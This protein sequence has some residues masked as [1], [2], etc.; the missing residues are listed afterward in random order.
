MCGHNTEPK[1]WDCAAGM[2]AQLERIKHRQ[3]SAVTCTNTETDLVH[4]QNS[5]LH[6]QLMSVHKKCQRSDW[7]PYRILL[8]FCPSFKGHTHTNCCPS[9]TD[10]F[11]VW[12]L[13]FSFVQ[14]LQKWTLDSRSYNKT[15]QKTLRMAAKG[16]ECFHLC[17]AAGANW[18]CLRMFSEHSP[19][20][21]R[22]I[23]WISAVMKDE[24]G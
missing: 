5:S 14:A 1:V 22:A 3:K 10:I 23:A 19:A 24:R 11:S 9:F 12:F 6:W 15:W 17:V 4:R 20:P 13:L 21:V 7:F 16:K 8:F 18:G 2:A